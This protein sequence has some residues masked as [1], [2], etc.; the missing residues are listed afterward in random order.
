MTNAFARC[1]FFRYDIDTIVLFL[2]ALSEHFEM[3]NNLLQGNI[4][5]AIFE[6]QDLTSVD[7]SRNGFISVIPS[8]I[9]HLNRL[10]VVRLNNNKLVGSIPVELFEARSIQELMLQ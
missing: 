10:E 5:H 1:F 9:G 8:N 6:C 3:K 4:P 2:F 7:L